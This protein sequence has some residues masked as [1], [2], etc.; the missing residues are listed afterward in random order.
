MGTKNAVN[1]QEYL[2]DFSVDGGA[3]GA[4]VLSDNNNKNSLPIGAIVKNVYARV[5]TAVD[6]AGDSATIKWGNA[7]GDYHG[8]V[9]E[10]SLTENAVFNAQD[11]T[12]DNLLNDADPGHPLA[13]YVADAD[14][15]KFQIT[16]A[17]EDATAG[18]IVFVVEYLYPAVEL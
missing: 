9:A 10:A 14:A 16:V 8:A 13:Y 2:W 11:D 3:S 15:A 5:I 17:G 12:S 1:V 18:K 6:S 4:I 7:S